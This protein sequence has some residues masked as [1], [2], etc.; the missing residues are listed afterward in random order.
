M[1]KIPP[2]DQA[3]L[4]AGHAASYATA[5]LDGSHTA[6]QLGD[7]ADRLFLEL[8]IVESPE[9]SSFLIPV[10]LLAITMMRVAKHARAV[11]IDGDDRQN[12][13]NLVMASLVDLVCLESRL[14][15]K[16]D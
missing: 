6:E 14:K 12:R 9:T 8:L 10:Q 2:I 4:L 16:K 15:V 11:S 7:N 5:F 1:T 3:N 13:W